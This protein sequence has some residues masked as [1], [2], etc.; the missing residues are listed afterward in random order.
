MR[1]KI[2]LVSLFS[3]LMV[4]ILAQTSGLNNALKV[5]LEEKNAPGLTCDVLVQGDMTRL[6]ENQEVYHYKVN[7][8]AGDIASITIDINKINALLEKRIILYAEYIAASK[9][10]LSDT[11]IYR[12]R[13]KSVK[14]WTAPL[15]Q[16]YNGEGVLMGIVDSGIDFSHPD[17]K[18]SLGKSRVQFLWDQTPTLGS[19]VPQPFNYGIE[20]TKNQ[21]DNNQC[22]H[23]DLPYYGHGTHVSG[24]AAGNARATGRFEGVASKSDI[25]FVALDFNRTGP[26]IADAINYIFTKANTVC[27]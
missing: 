19:I 23:S 3:S 24:I 13:I 20:W 26:A 18:D 5:I 11:M 7:Y 2:L 22:T 9:K 14:L 21:I 16:A 10:P 17:F 25:V 8:F 15:P 1:V 4:N 27:D 12:N 6:T